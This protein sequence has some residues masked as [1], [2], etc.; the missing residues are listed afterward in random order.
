MPLSQHII[1][2]TRL[3]LRDRVLTFKER[4]TIVNVAVKEGVPSDEINQ[5]LDNALTERLK[6]FTK[7]E[8]KRCPFCG[9]QIPLVQNSCPFCGN[10]LQNTDNKSVPPPFVLG[11]EADIIHSENMRVRQEES[12]PTTCPDCGA[13]FPLVGNVCNS[14]G[15]ILHE[16]S[17]SELHIDNLIANIKKSIIRLKNVPEPSFIDVLFQYGPIYLFLSMYFFLMI[18]KNTFPFYMFFTS[19]S[20]FVYLFK[21]DDNPLSINESDDYYYEAVHSYEMYSRMVRTLYGKSQEAKTILNV[22]SSKIEKLKKSR[23]VNQLFLVIYFFLFFGG[24]A[25]IRNILINAL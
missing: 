11:E 13:P 24:V 1:D 16:K 23:L 22:F 10:I 5:Y 20:I 6:S 14:C 9:A 18:D 7:E 4:E 25:I 21:S 8:L 3:A 19:V 17:G 2:L 15:H 12:N